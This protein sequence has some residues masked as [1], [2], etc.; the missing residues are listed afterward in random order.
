MDYQKKFI[1]IGNKNAITYKEI[2]R[3]IKDEK[4]WLGD[5]SPKEFILPNG[6]ITK[7]VSGLCRWF[8]N[9]NHKKRNECLVLHKKYNPQDYPKYDNYEAIEVSKVK[10]IPCDKYIELIVGEERLQSLKETYGYDLE[11]LEEIPD[12]V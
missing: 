3:Y 11:V 2:F 5:T 12:E 1:I 10:D 8:T 9:L 4:I 7:K 6:E